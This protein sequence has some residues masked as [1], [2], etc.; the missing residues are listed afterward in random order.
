[1]ITPFTNG[2][3]IL[4]NIAMNSNITFGGVYAVNYEGHYIT[5]ITENS[6]S[7]YTVGMYNGSIYK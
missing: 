7:N 6:T 3:N 5:A 2:K 4:Q 1:M